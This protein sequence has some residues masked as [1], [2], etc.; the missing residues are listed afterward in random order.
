[1]IVCPLI[2]SFALETFWGSLSKRTK[3]VVVWGTQEQD[4]EVELEEQEVQ[5]PTAKIIRK[6]RS[7][8]L[9]KISD[10]SNMMRLY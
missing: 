3:F 5:T 1:M 8:G 10:L 9:R 4:L 6:R 2:D 7:L